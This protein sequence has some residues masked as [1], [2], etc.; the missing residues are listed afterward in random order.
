[1][2]VGKKKTHTHTKLA[3][4]KLFLPRRSCARI[5]I[6]ATRRRRIYVVE[7]RPSIETSTCIIKINREHV[8]YSTDLERKMVFS[9][10]FEK[11][12]LTI[13]KFADHKTK[14]WPVSTYY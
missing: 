8:C 6:R 5:I 7:C 4:K 10:I 2:I 1:M 12:E 13:V 14:A 9:Q 11:L 3:K